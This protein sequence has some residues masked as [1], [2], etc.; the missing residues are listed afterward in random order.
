MGVSLKSGSL[1]MKQLIPIVIFLGVV[2]GKLDSEWTSAENMDLSQY[3]LKVVGIEDFFPDD[4]PFRDLFPGSKPKPKRAA[5]TKVGTEDLSD[6]CGVENVNLGRVVGGV[7][8]TPFAYPW[9]V[10]IIAEGRAFCTGSIISS[11][12]V[13]TAAH[14]VDGFASFKVFTGI[15]SLRR[16]GPQAKVIKS[17]DGFAHPEWNPRMVRNDLALIE[18]PSPIEFDDYRKPACL[19][20]LHDETISFTNYPAK[21]MGWGKLSDRSIGSA[22]ELHEVTVPIISNK[23]CSQTYGRAITPG[24]ICINSEGGH[25]VCSGD[26]GGPMNFKF[27]EGKWKQIGV[28]S[29]VHGYGCESGYPHA[30]TRLSHYLKW[31]QS[32]TGIQIFKR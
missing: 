3:D 24:H 12:Y 18:L 14:C 8:S 28:A 29:F 2:A 16:P 13:L 31:I 5:G 10:A 23:K 11:K 19:P 6:I 27:A 22:T 4:F 30:Y 32:E 7:E 17:Y 15:H 25:G 26:S 20:S 21:L 9:V 1:K